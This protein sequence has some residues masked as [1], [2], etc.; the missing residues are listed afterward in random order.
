[1]ER[2]VVFGFESARYVPEATPCTSTPDAVAGEKV[3]AA[4]K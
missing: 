3:D 1:M 2:P 4:T